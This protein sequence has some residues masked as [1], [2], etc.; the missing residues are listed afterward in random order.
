MRKTKFTLD[1]LLII[2]FLISVFTSWKSPS[3]NQSISN[4]SITPTSYPYMPAI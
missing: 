2:A 1:I 4:D 3:T